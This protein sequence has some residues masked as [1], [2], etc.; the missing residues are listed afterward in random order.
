MRKWL[1]ASACLVT[2]LVLTAVLIAAMRDGGQANTAGK[3]LPFDAASG[4]TGQSRATSTS[5]G[6]PQRS[7]D[8]PP[9]NEL[10]HNG[11]AAVTTSGWSADSD[12]GDIQL[13]RTAVGG[14]YGPA[15]TAIDIQRGA[16]SGAWAVV[17]VRIDQP[18]SA[19]QVNRS[20]RVRAFF[21]DLLTS[22][23]SVGIRIANKNSQ[24]GPTDTVQYS[25]AADDSWRLIDFSFIADRPAADDAGVYIALPA[26]GPIHLQVTGVSVQPSATEP[27][28]DMPAPDRTLSFAGD[29]GATPK[30]A[31]WN[32]DV[33]GGGWGN[34]EMQTYTEDARNGSLDGRGNLVITARR[35]VR[36]GPDGI[37]REYTSSRLTTQGK[38]DVEPGS[39]VEAPIRPAAGAGVWP[40]F[41]LQGADLSDAGWPAVGELDAM[42]IFGA[43]QSVARQFIHMSSEENSKRDLSYGEGVPGNKTDLGHSLDSQTHLYG[44]YFDDSRVDF[45]IDRQKT[46]SLTAADARASGRTWPFGRPQFLIVNVAVGGLAGDPADTSFPR[47]MTVG[48]ISMW[49]GDPPFDDATS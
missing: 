22:D 26:S 47:T 48:D 29:Q 49:S 38:V 46:L 39:Y 23:R 8:I 45:Y 25:A 27:A 12:A 2:A 5:A 44:V 11:S 18:G 10:V 34:D 15:S 14:P 6:L 37:Q 3:S 40:A 19:F 33:G 41:W 21:R 1:I 35:E 24:G 28:T 4:Q 30:A 43:Q 9:G 7:R 20:Y 42:E 13:S 16:G 32:Y 31:E 17:Q 36:T